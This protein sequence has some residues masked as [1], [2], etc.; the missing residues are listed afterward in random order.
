MPPVLA[1]G[2]LVGRPRLVNGEKP[3]RVQTTRVTDRVH[4]RHVGYVYGKERDVI[5]MGGVAYPCTI[6]VD[7]PSGLGFV[8]Y[9]EIG[10]VSFLPNREE[11]RDTKRTQDTLIALCDEYGR[12]ILRTA[13]ADVDSAQSRPE[14]LAKI[15]KWEREIPTKVYKPLTYK[16]ADVPVFWEAPKDKPFVVTENS[17]PLGHKRTPDKIY[18]NALTDAL[19]VHG[20]DLDSFTPTHKKKLVHYATQ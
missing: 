5:V 20:Y 12:E 6:D 18:A 17:G 10:E 13:Q 7:L 1:H 3:K 8:C 14:A 2:T 9:V 16:G 19:L 11:L 4:T 15:V